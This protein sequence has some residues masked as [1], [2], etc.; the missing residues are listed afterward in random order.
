[1]W[2][3]EGGEMSGKGRARRAFAAR[4]FRRLVRTATA[5]GMRPMNVD[6]AG[7]CIASSRRLAKAAWACADAF[8]AGEK[9]RGQ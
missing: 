2:R 3:M 6:I 4:I 8:F 9:E 7:A 1:M 5:E